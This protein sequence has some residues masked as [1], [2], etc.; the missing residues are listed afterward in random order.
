MNQRPTLKWPHPKKQTKTKKQKISGA[1]WTW[2]STCL[3]ADRKWKT[4]LLYW[5]VFFT[6]IVSLHSKA[7]LTAILNQYW[8]SKAL[9]LC[10]YRS[11]PSA[12]L[13][14]LGTFWSLSVCWRRDWRTAIY[15]AFIYSRE[16]REHLSSV[17]FSDVWLWYCTSDSYRE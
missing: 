15:A 6:L 9:V 4:F 11:M 1:K 10:V 5:H 3:L 2:L 17:Q 8:R 16:I 12:G 7:G 14:F 13:C